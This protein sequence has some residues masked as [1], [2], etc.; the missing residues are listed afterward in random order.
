MVESLPRSRVGDR[1]E[2]GRVQ[3]RQPLHRSKKGQ[4]NGRQQFEVDLAIVDH[5]KD[6][7]AL[8]APD[9]DGGITT[10]AAR[11]DQDDARRSAAHR[12]TAGTPTTVMPEPT[13]RTTIEFPPTTTS[14][15][16]VRF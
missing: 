13:S 14:E 3:R 5:A 6:L 8:E 2:V 12:S 9:L 15:P 1:E 16:I 4:I 7:D 11:T 10:V